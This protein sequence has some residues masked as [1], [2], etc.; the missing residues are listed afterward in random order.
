[1]PTGSETRH[2]RLTQL[3]G[4]RHDVLVLKERVQLS[5]AGRADGGQCPPVCKAALMQL[6][7]A[8]R[9]QAVWVHRRAQCPQ[10]IPERSLP[11]FGEALVQRRGTLGTDAGYR[12]QLLLVQMQPVE[13][14]IEVLCF[15]Q[16][17]PGAG[18]D[19]VQVQRL[20]AAEP[21]EAGME[22]PGATG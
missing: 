16:F 18:A 17:L 11:R 1:V 22:L 10:P 2:A 20:F 21:G 14:A 5:R 8:V 15:K 12:Q 3:I 4:K 19:A 6:P 7:P 13:Q 9:R